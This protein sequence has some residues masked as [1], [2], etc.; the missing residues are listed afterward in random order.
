MADYAQHSQQQ[1]SFPALC[2][3]LRANDVE[4]VYPVG[5]SPDRAVAVF[6]KK[7]AAIFSDGDS[8]RAAPDVPFGRD[9]AGNEIFILA[10]CFAG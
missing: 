4:L 9:E 6:A 7:E 1:S 5:Y 3:S 10:A 8:D 2:V